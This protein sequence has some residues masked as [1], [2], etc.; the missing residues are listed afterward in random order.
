MPPP[1]LVFG[2]A[3][4]STDSSFRVGGCLHRISFLGQ[5]RPP[6]TLVLSR[7]MYPPTLA[8]GSVS[9]RM[10]LPTQKRE[11]V[12][13]SADPKDRV[14]G[15][16]C[17]PKTG[18]GGGLCRPKTGVG[19]GICRLQF[20]VSGGILRL[21]FLGRQMHPPTQKTAHPANCPLTVIA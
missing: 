7:W 18:V 17:R 11:S 19:G 9:W 10:H 4:A 13:A 20:W 8:F 12:E 14:G 16:L 15:G 6:L 1:T 3:E 2:L 5:W 21:Y